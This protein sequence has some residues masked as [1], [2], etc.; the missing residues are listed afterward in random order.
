MDGWHTDQRLARLIL[1]LG[2]V[3]QYAALFGLVAKTGGLLSPFASV[4][5]GAAAYALF[6]VNTS[7]SAL[8]IAWMTSVGFVFLAFAGER[9]VSGHPT[10]WAYAA[11]QIML[12]G[13]W[14]FISVAGS[15]QASQTSSTDV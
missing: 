12:I 10:V 5:A 3:L 9:P 6:L 4:A 1:F 7:R 2:G 15:R 8:L 13:M 11:A 14:T